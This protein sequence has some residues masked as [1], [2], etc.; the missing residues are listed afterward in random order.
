MIKTVTAVQST[1]DLKPT[2]I[3]INI[4]GMRYSQTAKKIYGS[5]GKFNFLCWTPFFSLGDLPSYL[6]NNYTLLVGEVK[7]NI[8]LEMLLLR[9][10]GD[11]EVQFLTE[12]LILSC[13][14]LFVSHQE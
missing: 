6:Y 12:A 9:V 5:Q 13:T 8:V 2:R 4:F 3:I 1:I 11:V 7:K 10:F 14:Y